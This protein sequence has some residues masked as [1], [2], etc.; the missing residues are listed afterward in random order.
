MK[1][2]K[3]KEKKKKKVIFTI[4]I[5]PTKDDLQNSRVTK[6]KDHNHLWTSKDF[7]TDTP[8]K[9]PA[10]LTKYLPSTKFF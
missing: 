8:P 1:T 9:I 4:V 6:G 5:L 3:R 7:A 2:K 10:P